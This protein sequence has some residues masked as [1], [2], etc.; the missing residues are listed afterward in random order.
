MNRVSILLFVNSFDIY[1]LY[2]WK[3][4]MLCKERSIISEVIQIV[5][6]LSFRFC[7][8]YSEVPNFSEPNPDYRGQQNKGVIN[9]NVLSVFMIRLILTVYYK[10]V[11]RLPSFSYPKYNGDKF[12][13][14]LFKDSLMEFFSIL[15]VLWVCI[16]ICSIIYEMY[17]QLSVS[18]DHSTNWDCTGW[19]CWCRTFLY[20]GL[21]TVRHICTRNFYIFRFWYLGGPGTNPRGILRDGCMCHLAV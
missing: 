21:T 9:A 10:S 16:G 7:M 14:N 8:V 1:V 20:R 5:L 15:Y 12:K 11:A 19:I 2:S 13:R 3:L 4:C 17:S 18:M 6:L